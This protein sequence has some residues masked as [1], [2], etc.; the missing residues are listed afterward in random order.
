MSKNSPVVP[1]I[2][3]NSI[4]CMK[5]SKGLLDC[6]VN[7]QPILYPAVEENAARLRYFITS[8]HTAEQIRFTV[9][10]MAEVLDK[11]DPSY[12]AKSFSM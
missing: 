4:H 7:V 10:A 8:E 5:L 2:L 6:G 12:L 1:I 3:G 9:D 11:I